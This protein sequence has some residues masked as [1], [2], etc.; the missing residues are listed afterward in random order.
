[1]CWFSNKHKFFLLSSYCLLSS[2]HHHLKPLQTAY[3]K[4][5]ASILMGRYTGLL[6]IWRLNTLVDRTLHLPLDRAQRDLVWIQEKEL[7]HLWW[8]N[9]KNSWFLAKITSSIWMEPEIW[10]LTSNVVFC[11]GKCW[12][13]VYPLQ[14]GK[15]GLICISVGAVCG[16]LT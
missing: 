8:G 1:M 2:G 3:L 16:N 11:I 5:L 9:H 4:V 13:R 14:S 10:L 6:Q 7:L 15:R 12:C